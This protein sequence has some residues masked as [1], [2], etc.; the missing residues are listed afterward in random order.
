MGGGG[1]KDGGGGPPPIDPKLAQSTYQDWYKKGSLGNPYHDPGVPEYTQYAA[2]G[3]E[4]G[5]QARQQQEMLSQLQASFAMPEM[6]MYEGPSY[7][8]QLAE[9]KKQIGIQN[10]DE[11]FA[12]YLDAASAAAD[13]VTSE[14][15][16]EQA[17]ANLLGIDY[18]IDNQQRQQRI[19]NYFATIWGEG[20][21]TQ[22]ESLINEYGAPEGFTGWTVQRG[23]PSFYQTT[24][25]G[26]ETTVGVT[27][28][29]KPM[30]LEEDEDVLGAESTV[31]GV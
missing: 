19:N 15:E 13:Y 29:Q 7:E 9:Q 12:S 4:A 1:G 21:Q 14:I 25:P 5:R 2:Q 17:N 31:L 28:G 26:E 27:K 6:P 8:E 22:L 11:L 24:K 20:Q 23:D 18:N 16:A 3:Y 30:L 10:R